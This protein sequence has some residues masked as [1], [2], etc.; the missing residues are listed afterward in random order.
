MARPRGSKNKKTQAG[1]DQYDLLSKR[2][3]VSPMEFLFQILS[4][5][6]PI[7]ENAKGEL[8]STHPTLEMMADAA[9][10]LIPY[11]HPKLSSTDVNAGKGAGGPI[12]LVIDM[13]N[14][15]DF[16]LPAEAATDSVTPTH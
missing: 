16:E 14:A 9:K 11:K 10:N 4:D 8:I 13:T 5:T 6:L 12:Q 1:L 2:Y 15:G 7:I 3:G